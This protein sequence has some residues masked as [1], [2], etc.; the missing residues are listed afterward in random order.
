MNRETT[1]GRKTDALER[2]N[3]LKDGE[4]R[5]QSEAR[6]VGGMSSDV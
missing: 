2:G 3:V 1:M 4:R 6:A 5:R